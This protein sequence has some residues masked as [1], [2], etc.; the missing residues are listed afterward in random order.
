[1]KINKKKCTLQILELAGA[2]KV[3][4]KTIKKATAGSA[5]L[6]F[7]VIPHYVRDGDDVVVTIKK[8]IP[9]SV[10]VTIFGKLYKAKKGEFS[11]DADSGT[12]NFSGNLDG[13]YTIE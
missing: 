2:D 4:N 5:G 10:K 9:K 7:T 12:I 6:H 11:Y 8:G 3:I 1:M 13:S